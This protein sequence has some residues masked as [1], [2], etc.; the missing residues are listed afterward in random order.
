MLECVLNN[1]YK[2]DLLFIEALKVHYYHLNM[3][4]TT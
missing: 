3:Q 4:E 1:S 2:N